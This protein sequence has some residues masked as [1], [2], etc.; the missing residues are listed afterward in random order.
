MMSPRTRELGFM[1]PAIALGLL[2]IGTVASARADTIDAGPWPA[3]L[4]VVGVFLVMH[5]ALRLRAPQADPYLLP[6][7][8]LLVAIGLVEL[9]RVDP[10]LA[11]DQA[12]WVA[13][14][15]AVF[16]AV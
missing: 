13:V 3:A 6:I 8:G 9:D 16:D 14:G 7:V 11:A 2:G 4:G 12:A 10:A 5:L 1:V 15:G